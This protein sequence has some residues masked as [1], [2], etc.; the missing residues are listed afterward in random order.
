MFLHLSADLLSFTVATMPIRH[1]SNKM[2]RGKRAKYRRKQKKPK[3]NTLC[4]NSLN[5]TSQLLGKSLFIAFSNGSARQLR[6]SFSGFQSECEWNSWTQLDWLTSTTRSVCLSLRLGVELCVH[7]YGPK[8][9]DDRMR[10]PWCRALLFNRLLLF[11][12]HCKVIKCVLPCQKD[13]N[14][15]N[16]FYCLIQH[17][18]PGWWSKENT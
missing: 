12:C 7:C 16:S 10:R 18:F 5:L 1:N 14:L 3:K 11:H 4:L 15:P 13:L 6:Q 8:A 17:K 2:M 9:S